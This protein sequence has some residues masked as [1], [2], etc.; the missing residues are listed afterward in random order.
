MSEAGLAR[1]DIIV[2]VYRGEA[3]V[4]RCLDALFASDATQWADVILVD[5]AS[6]EPAVS[7][8]LRQWAGMPSVTLITHKTNLGFVDS[9]NEAAQT[10]PDRDFVILN[11]D[12]EVS[13]D[14]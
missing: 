11:A 1:V 13:S 12:T 3:A 14:W 8:C 2:P 10:H 4:R 9:V 7:S 6:P 5:D